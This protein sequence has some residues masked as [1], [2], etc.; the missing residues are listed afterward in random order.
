MSE[1]EIE[2][3]EDYTREELHQDLLCYTS[4]VLKED[5]VLT[6]DM[7]AELYISFSDAPDTDFVVRVTDVDENGRSISW[8]D[9]CS[10]PD[11][12]MALRSEFLQKGEIVLPEDPHHQVVQLLP[13][14]PPHPGDYHL[15]RQ[16]FHLPNSNTREGLLPPGPWWPITGYTT[17]ET[18]PP[19]RGVVEPQA[20]C[21]PVG[22][23]NRSHSAPQPSNPGQK[24]PGLFWFWGVRAIPHILV[25]QPRAVL[26]P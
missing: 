4:P 26:E 9:G 1:N 5:L 19:A 7:T 6:G 17:V 22:R 24:R 18:L 10:A 20:D 21:H 12:V 15:Q 23:A 16:E 13:E 25:P 8:R 14:R 2:V 11:T 3:P